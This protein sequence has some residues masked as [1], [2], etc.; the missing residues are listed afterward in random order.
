M[1]MILPHMQ[2]I[3]FDKQKNS[4]LCKKIPTTSPMCFSASQQDGKD[5]YFLNSWSHD[6]TWARLPRNKGWVNLPTGSSYLTL[7]YPL[8]LLD[9]A[10]HSLHQCTVFTKLD[11][12]NA[13]HLVRIREGMSGRQ[14]SIPLSAILNTWLCL[15]V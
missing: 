2:K 11:L 7:P 13:Y 15:L 5:G 12:R 1:T 10:F 3:Y 6:K 14:H 8:P 9:S 4:F